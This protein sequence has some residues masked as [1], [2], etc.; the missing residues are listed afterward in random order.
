M[1]TG[2]DILLYLAYKTK[3][4]WDEMYECIKNKTAIE[5]KEVLKIKESLNNEYITLIDE[6][7][8]CFFKK[9]SKPPFVLFY[10]GD[11]S[12]VKNDNIKKVGFVG[13]R[14][15]SNYGASATKSIISG[16]D[17]DVVIVSGLARGIDTISHR[18]AINNGLKTIAVLGSGLNE[19]YPKENTSLFDDIISHDGLIISEYYDNVEA[20]P[21]HFVSRNRLIAAFSN[22]V[23]VGEA[24]E[25][26]GTSI[27]VSYALNYGK[28]VGCIPYEINKG[29]IC[30][31][32]IKEGALLIESGEDI[33]KV[34]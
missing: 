11:I 34:L 3:S 21:E 18:A 27:T 12:L 25:R 17:K 13:S 23:V 2:R 4:N 28:D 16:L 10:K 7:F 19:I 32:L 26:S 30:N 9:M 15:N 22:L 1:L 29:S 24:Y 33:M 20:K 31:T 5:E 6:D 14:K 8:P